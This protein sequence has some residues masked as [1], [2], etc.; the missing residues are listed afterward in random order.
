MKFSEL[1]VGQK[2]KFNNEEYIKTEPTKVSCCKTLNSVKVQNNEKVM[3]RP[4]S[5]VE[6]IVE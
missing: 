1:T 3:I 6:A 5:D 4:M 2:F